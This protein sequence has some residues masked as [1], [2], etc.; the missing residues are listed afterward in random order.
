MTIKELIAEAE[1]HSSYDIPYG[2]QVLLLEMAKML[3]EIADKYV[4]IR[5]NTCSHE[6]CEDC[7]SRLDGW[8]LGI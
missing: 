7:D 8:Q 6:N 1:E 5:C 2:T 3:K 4:P